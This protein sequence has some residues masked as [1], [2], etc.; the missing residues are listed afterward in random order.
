MTLNR[1]ES[2]SLASRIKSFNLKNNIKLEVAPTNLYLSEIQNIFKDSNIR[3]IS[4][5][6]DHVS[7]GSFTGG[8][9]L[10][11]LREIG[12][13][14]TI[15]GHSE[16]RSK[17]NE[18][19]YI[20]NQKLESVLNADFEV[21]FCF[22]SYK[23]IPFKIISDNLNDI[24][25]LTLAYEPTW[26]IGTGK[27]ASISHIEEIHSK[28]NKTLQKLSLRSIPLLYGGSVNPEN[29]NEILNTDNVDGVLVGGASTNLELLSGIINSI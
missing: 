4:Q 26:A 5:N 7:S 28:V 20:V 12:I 21:I 2:V 8:I 16:R 27:T 9:C 13:T 25:K 17:F 19:D 23:Q 24:S 22:D 18:T 1:K 11:Q 10:D 6:F 14:K 29:S 3:V 15:L